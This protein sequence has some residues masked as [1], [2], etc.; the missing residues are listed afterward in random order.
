M[1][2]YGYVLESGTAGPLDLFRQPPGFTVT[3]HAQG[4]RDDQS[5]RRGRRLE[6]ALV[7]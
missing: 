2:V 4:A 6:L 7:P 5:I 1:S 3:L